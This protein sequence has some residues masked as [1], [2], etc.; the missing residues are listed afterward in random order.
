MPKFASPAYTAYT[1]CDPEAMSVVESTACARFPPTLP[2]VATPSCRGLAPALK[3]VTVPVGTAPL[4]VAPVTDAVSTM[5]EPASAAVV[6][7]VKVIVG[8]VGAVVP[9]VPV[10]AAETLP[11]KLAS[12]E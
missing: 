5:V 9:G 10:I 4:A 6:L 8:A 1:D 7:A 12:P 11:A 2:S 3:N